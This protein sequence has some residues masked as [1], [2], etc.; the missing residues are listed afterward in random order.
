MKSVALEGSLEH[1]FPPEVLQLLQLA[2]ATGRLTLTRGA[3]RVELAIERGRPVF[4]QT[5]GVT[6]HVGE[7][8]VHRGVIPR[9]AL[10]MLLA[11]QEDQPGLRIGTM[12]IQAGVATAEQVEGAVREVLRRIIYGVLL[13][14]EGRFRFEPFDTIPQE[15]IRIDLDLDRLIL[16]GMRLADQARAA[17]R[18]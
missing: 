8:L 1:F 7:V 4:A 5:S 12:L 9:E 14:R 15:D 2:Q 13:W 11:Q 17:A 10:D 18:A 3:E 6:V 16:E